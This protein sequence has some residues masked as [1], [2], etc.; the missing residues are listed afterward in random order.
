MLRIFNRL[1]NLEGI[2]GPDA[3]VNVRGEIEHQVTALRHHHGLI[4]QRRDRAN[5]P[6]TEQQHEKAENKQT[7][8]RTQKRGE[9]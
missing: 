7:H 8:Q 5:D 2:R 3:I 1:K 4:A 6:H 9:E